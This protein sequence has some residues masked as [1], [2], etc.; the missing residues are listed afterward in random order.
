MNEEK[1]QQ[2]YLELLKLKN[3]SVRNSIYTLG[4][5]TLMMGASQ[6]F[7]FLFFL[8]SEFGARIVHFD[9]YYVQLIFPI[10]SVVVGI[11]LVIST[12]YPKITRASVIF[13]LLIWSFVFVASITEMFTRGG[14]SILWILTIPILHQIYYITT[15]GEF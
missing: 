10:V 2:L 11:L 5:T 8:N 15:R 1:T 4:L 12:K 6:A 3:L 13:A 7:R 14:I 9:G